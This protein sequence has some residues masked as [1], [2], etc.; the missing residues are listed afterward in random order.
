MKQ[1]FR[2]HPY[3]ATGFVLATAVTLFFVV[4]ILVS[5]IY[6]ANPAHHN[7]TVKPWMTVGYIGTSW[8]LEPAEIDALAGLPGPKD[9]TGKS[10][11]GPWTLQQIADARGVP[12]ADVI[13]EVNAAL[14]KLQADQALKA[15]P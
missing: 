7:E 8:H 6:W 12:V 11:H 2:A 1:I 15:V 4:R 3:A 5:A 10:H 14:A 9:G 13:N